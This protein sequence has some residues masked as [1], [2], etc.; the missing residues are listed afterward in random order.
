M[1]SRILVFGGGSA[2]FLTAIT[3]KHR[4]PRLN[5]TVVRSR[6]I[7]VIGVGEATTVVLPQHMHYY[8]GL[9]PREFYR[10]AEPQW[11]L[12][13]R[14]LWGKRPYFDYS[15]SPQLDTQYNRIPKGPA[16]FCDDG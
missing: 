7:G 11:K 16:H 9:A 10:L 8:L 5:V 15:F 2:G 12:G 6:E 3:L 14:F 1:V 4:V 13:I